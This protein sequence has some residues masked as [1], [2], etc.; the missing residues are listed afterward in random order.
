M[1]EEI[2]DQCQDPTQS[3]TIDLPCPLAE[4]V[5]RYAKKNG[6]DVAAVLIEAL[7]GFL[8]KQG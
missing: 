4:R 7:D 8:R 6:T 3:I 5:E 1:T 2:K